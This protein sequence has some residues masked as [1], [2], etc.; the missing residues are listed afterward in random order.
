VNQVSKTNS[1]VSLH[2]LWWDGCGYLPID[3]C[4][5]LRW[6]YLTNTMFVVIPPIYAVWVRACVRALQACG[7]LNQNRQGECAERL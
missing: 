2:R 1:G 7:A 3:S 4:W 5:D 6:T